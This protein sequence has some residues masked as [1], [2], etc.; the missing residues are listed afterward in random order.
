VT[1]KSHK[2][3][4]SL[5]SFS[6]KQIPSV[7]IQKCWYLQERLHCWMYCLAWKEYSVFISCWL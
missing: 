2:V 6:P 3:L 4:L 1:T 7:W 5:D